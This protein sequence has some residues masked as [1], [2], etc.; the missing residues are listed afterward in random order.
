MQ[1]KLPTLFADW[2]F[3]H[4]IENESRHW[5]GLARAPKYLNIWGFWV[6]WVLHAVLAIL[7]YKLQKS[8]PWGLVILDRKDAEDILSLP[9]QVALTCA[10][11]CTSNCGP[12][13]PWCSASH[14]VELWLRGNMNGGKLWLFTAQLHSFQTLML[15]RS[16]KTTYSQQFKASFK[17]LLMLRVYVHTICVHSYAWQVTCSSNQVWVATCRGSSR[18][19]IGMVFGKLQQRLTLS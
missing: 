19:I 11:S 4:T 1:P 15:W 6:F 5:W 13:L 2:E 9:L 7:T 16:V 10:I 3:E 8:N 12:Y 18:A 14:T 17:Y